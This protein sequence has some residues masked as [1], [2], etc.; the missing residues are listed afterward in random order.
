MGIAD[1]PDIDEDE[2]RAHQADTFRRATGPISASSAFMASTEP[3]MNSVLD[4]TSS[5]SEPLPEPPPR[6]QVPLDGMAGGPFDTGPGG[7]FGGGPTKT[8]E[9]PF[10]GGQQADP[11]ALFDELTS[12]DGDD[13]LPSYKAPPPVQDG[14]GGLGQMAQ[15][16]WQGDPAKPGFF[17]WAGQQVG[18]LTD[19]ARNQGFTQNNP[20]G[21]ALV[22][23]GEG[24]EGALHG[25]GGSAQALREGNVVGGLA[26]T[27]SA[28]LNAVGDI[29]RGIA[30]EG[31]WPTRILPGID[32]ETPVIGGLNNPRELVGLATDLLIPE[33]AIE[34]M[35]GK[36]IGKVAKGRLAAGRDGR[37]AS[38]HRHRGG[39]TP[40]PRQR[41]SI[42]HRR[43]DQV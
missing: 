26:G 9:M 10:F 22:G 17:S 25:L 29:P 20:L 21:T 23:A 12:F 4:A 3:L 24:I 30:T 2:W 1:L 28:A 43:S 36:G 41:H 15:Q 40:V 38:R 19:R 11:S 16:A 33:T 7:P 34:R 13:D 37:G 31:Q 18:N 14:L 32:P 39:Q 42:R 6:K 35:V 5:L 27:A 8:A